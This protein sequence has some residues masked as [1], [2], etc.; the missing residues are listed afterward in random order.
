M[1]KLKK[2]DSNYI[3]KYLVLFFACVVLGQAEINKLSPFLFALFFAGIYVGLDEKLLGVFVLSSALLKRCSL[4]SFFT[5]ITVIAVGIIQKYVFRLT[6][7]K[8]PLWSVFLG[9]FIS[10]VT[11][12]YYNYLHTFD[13][14]VYISLGMVCL[15]VFISVLHVLCL[16]KNC[17]KLTLDESI[18]FLF[19]I[20]LI[21]LGLSNI[22]IFG[23]E[24]YRLILC[25][26]IFLLV[27]TNGKT[28][29]YS[30]VISFALGV[31]VGLNSLSVVAEFM[32]LTLFC[33]IFG[34]NSKAKTILI[35]FL[36]D[37]LIQY[38]F[39]NQNWQ[40]YVP[41][42]PMLVASVIF[43]FVPKK[44]LDNL[45]NLIYVKKSELSSRSLINTTRKAIRKRM[46]ELSNIFLEM[47]QIHMKMLKK[48][49]TR[50]ELIAMLKREISSTCCKDCLEKSRCNRSLGTD[51]LSNVE[52]MIE[53]AIEKGKLTLLDIPSGLTNRCMKVNVLI[54][55]IN[56][57]TDEYKQY[58]N[59]VSDI[60]NVKILLADQMGAVSKLLLDVG[61]EIDNNVSFDIAQ[62]NK[63]ISKLLSQNID[64]QEVLLYTEKKDDLS[65]ELVLKDGADKQD[66]IERIV[67][68][69]LKTKMKATKITPIGDSD[70]NSIT[71]KKE[72]KFDC[73][74][75]LAS[76]NKSGNIE[77]GDC[78]SIIRLGQSK[79]LLALCDGMG[80]G[81]SAHKMS[82][83]TLG[84]IENFYKAGFDNDVIMESV[85]KLLAINS[86]EE[87]S[88][89][90][91]CLIDLD[92]SSADFIK[93]GAPYGVI[94][95][96]GEVEIV[97]GGALP[98]GA[99]DNITPATKKIAIS[100][101]DL[102]ILATDGITDAFITQENMIDF[103]SHLA[104]NNP[105][106]VA[107]TILNEAIRLNNMSAKDDMTI[108][109][110]RTYLKY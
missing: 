38:S 102:I 58:K 37:I 7:R 74:F 44:C 106:S 88:T 1:W 86:Q 51:N 3:L 46:S 48:D 15:F 32:I 65:V 103:V 5:A 14:F 25:L 85:N 67:S 16:R 93:V 31:G 82:A 60:N 39:Y 43:L 75:G 8:M 66:L 89:L 99:L 87:Y 18:C 13:L 97:D 62:E 53:K 45:C 34:T 26:T 68:E 110:A 101:K 9:Y 20:A 92:L 47:K 35:M 12:I 108:L 10:L 84:L 50:Q 79:F 73:V 95:K 83:M 63:I 22:E 28:L 91:I 81:K 36:G 30:V 23:F 77:C 11:Y 96:D 78:H 41:L 100:S 57:L 54:S 104:S 6:K 24:I 107:E 90:D 49:L 76:C 27:F 40:I 71:L 72:C 69:N 105:Q 29:A 56:R 64:C 55:M 4:E 109:V 94:K 42:V 52:C 33:G 19:F 59:M 21:G 2:V 98:I 80:S 61:A 70:L 17:F